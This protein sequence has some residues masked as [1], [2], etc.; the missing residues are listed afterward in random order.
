MSAIKLPQIQTIPDFGL[1]EPYK[2]DVWIIHDWEYYKNAP[3]EQQEAWDTRSNSTKHNMVFDIINN[4]V[5]REELKYCMYKYYSSNIKLRTFG[6]K[7]DLLKQFTKFF[8]LHDYDSIINTDISEF[9]KYLSE[10]AHIKTTINNGT[11]VNITESKIETVT[12]KNK[13]VSFLE[14]CI[15][16]VNEYLDILDGKSIYERDI[17]KSKDFPKVGELECKRYLH[18]EN[19]Q[20]EEFKNILKEYCKHRISCVSFDTVFAHQ[21]AV[22]RFYE[23]IEEGSYELTHLSELNRDI[24]EDYFIWLRTESGFSQNLINSSIWRLKHFFETISL[25]DLPNIPQFDLIMDTDYAFK[26]EKAPN[27]FT[28]EELEA[29][30]NIIPKI[31]KPY[32]FV[33]FCLMMLGCRVSEVLNLKISQVKQSNDGS[34]YL[35]LHQHK[36]KAEYLKPLINQVDMVVNHLIKQNKKRFGENAVYVFSKD[37]EDK[38]LE[39][40]ALLQ[41]LNRVLI[42]ENVLDRD[43]LPI[44]CNTHRFRS[45]FATSIMQAGGDKRATAQMLGQK[46]LS[47]VDNYV[48]IPEKDKQFYFEPKLKDD[49]IFISNIDNMDEETLKDHENAIPLCNG[50]CTKNSA[51]GVCKKAN[52][53]LSCDAFVPSPAHIYTYERQ[54]QEIETTITLAKAN[55]MEIILNKSL[56]TKEDLERILNTL[57]EKGGYKNE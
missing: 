39:F 12:K 9:E 37:N 23:F 57:Y 55:R 44:H 40:S 56:K 31:K 19:I 16:W 5:I 46:T 33:V 24:L 15:K 53:C 54:L 3:K 49:Q 29:I 17:W 26:T 36:T 42:E 34:Y 14:T 7:Y 27:P 1:E 32:N 41:N 13:P 6:D 38:P 28:P 25:L 47:C 18:F 8:N 30:R 21:T 48:D 35:V 50:W 2:S 11:R 20:T 43:G 52:Y 10:V 45:T 51:F 22:L 4:P